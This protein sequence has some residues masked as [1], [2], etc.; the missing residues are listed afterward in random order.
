MR[1]EVNNLNCLN[2]VNLGNTVC[3]TKDDTI[4]YN[5]DTSNTNVQEQKKYLPPITINAIVVWRL[6]EQY[7]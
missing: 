5:R 2:L 3:A 6:Q 7:S 1:Q 4:L